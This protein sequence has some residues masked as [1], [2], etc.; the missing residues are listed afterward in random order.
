MIRPGLV[1]LA[2]LLMT[3]C[4]SPG[5]PPA[6]QAVLLKQVI[7]TKEMPSIRV[8]RTEGPAAPKPCAV[9]LAAAP[10]YPDGATALRDAPTIYEQVQLLLAGRALRMERER[11][12][13]ESLKRCRH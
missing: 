8:I 12:L 2:A 4:A 9:S 7:V 11:T 10:A 6:Q 3:A 13:T 1:S 5:P